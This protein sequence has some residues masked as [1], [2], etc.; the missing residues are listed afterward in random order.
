M[1]KAVL[2]GCGAISQHLT[3][4]HSLILF[5]KGSL[6]DTSALVGSLELEQVINTKDYVTGLHDMTLVD[7]NT[8]LVAGRKAALYDIAQS[9][10]TNLSLFNGS[11]ALKAVNYNGE[12]YTYTVI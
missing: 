2:I 10:F 11:T 5:H 8:L 1:K 12:L 3:F 4:F 9:S 7:D 6:V